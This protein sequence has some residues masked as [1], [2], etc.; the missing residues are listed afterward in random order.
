MLNKEDWMEIKAQIARG[1]YQKDI[2]DE[3]GVHPKTIRRALARQG[4][5]LGRR[6]NARKSKLDAF[7]PFIDELLRDG[8]WNACL[9][10]TSPSPRDS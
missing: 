2:A 9:L 5:P 8:V 1:V 10:Y 3:L 7:K 4:P 6:P